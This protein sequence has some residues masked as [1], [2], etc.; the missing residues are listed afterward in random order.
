MDSVHEILVIFQSNAF[1]DAVAF[2]DLSGGFF[3]RGAFDEV[4]GILGGGGVEM[5]NGSGI[6]HQRAGAFLAHAQVQT[7]GLLIEHGLQVVCAFGQGFDIFELVCK[8]VED[9]HGSSR[10]SRTIRQKR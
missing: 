4:I 9:F 8:A 1:A 2:G 6:D 7:V 3:G 10:V 5:Q